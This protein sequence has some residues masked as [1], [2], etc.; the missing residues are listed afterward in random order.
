MCNRELLFLK[1]RSTDSTQVSEGLWLTFCLDPLVAG[2]AK[3]IPLTPF[4]EVPSPAF[5]AFAAGDR[6]WLGWP[7]LGATLITH[8]GSRHE[9]VYCKWLGHEIV[10]Q[11]R[12]KMPLPSTFPLHQWEVSLMGLPPGGGWQHNPSPTYGFVDAAKVLNWE[13]IVCIGLRTWRPTYLY[14]S[15]VQSRSQPKRAKRMH[16]KPP[17]G[18]GEPLFANNTHVWSF[19]N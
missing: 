14:V 12:I 16:E 7:M 17:L 19:G 9:V 15:E 18:V 4:S 10:D 6:A 2:A 3:F 5:A 11:E 1:F 8:S 13:P